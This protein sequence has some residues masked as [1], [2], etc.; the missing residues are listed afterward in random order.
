MRIQQLT[1]AE[2]VASLQ[3]SFKGLEPAEAARRLAEFGP[4]AVE[5]VRAERPFGRFVRGFTH[6]FALVLWLAAGLALVA[7]WRA[8]GQ[9]MATLAVAIVGVILINGLFSFWQEHRAERA[10]AELQRLLPHRVRVTR[11]GDLLELDTTRLVP[12]DVILLE[13]GDDVPADCRLLEA[14]GLRANNATITGESVAVSRDASPSDEPEVIH[15]TNVLLAGTQVGAGRA[16]AVVFA[17]GMHSE[18]GKIAHLTQTAGEPLSPL[19]KEI[20]RLSRIIALLAM[21]LGAVF[22]VIGLALGLPFWANLTFAIGIIIANVPEGLLPTVTLALAMGSQRMARRN[23][24][25][26]HLPSVEALGSATV[27]CTDKTG[28]LTQNC[29][30]VREVVVAGEFHVAGEVP[31][32]LDG[33]PVSPWRHFIRVAALCQDVKEVERNGHLQRA[34]DPMELAMLSMA[35]RATSEFRGVKRIGELPFDGDRKRLSTLNRTPDGLVFCTKGAPETV[36]P[37]CDRAVD[38]G[39][40]VPITA[41]L[42]EQHAR[43]QQQMAERGL[44]VLAFA[45]REVADV[46]T[47]RTTPPDEAQLKSIE[48]GGLVLCGLVGLEDPPRPEVPE[49]VRKCR[50]AGIKVIMETGDHPG[51]AVAIGRQ[52]G[53]CTGEPLVITGEQLRRMTPIQL[54]LALDAPEVIF[55]R[56]GADQKLHIVRALKRKREIVAVTGDGVNDAPALRESDIGIAMGRSGTDVAREAA[57]MVLLDDNFA[58]IVAA[59]EEGRTVYANIR[60]FITY[61]LTSNIPEIIPYLAF[62]LFRIPLPLTVVQILTVDLGTDMLPA[63]ALGAEPPQPDVMRR[64]PRPLG[65]RLFDVPLILRAYLFLGPIEAVAALASFFFVLHGAGWTYGTAL[66][67]SDPLYRQATTACL[68]AIIVMQIVNVFLCRH[69]RESSRRIRLRTAKWILLAVA[70]EVIVILLLNYTR[71]GNAVAGTAPI[72]ASVWL[73]VVPFAVAMLV[74]EEIRKG[75]VRRTAKRVSAGVP[76]LR[77]ELT[78]ASSGTPGGAKPDA[79]C[80]RHV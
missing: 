46:G 14:A 77:P 40:I 17:T 34:G 16:T 51:T 18:L 12:G 66:G 11:G 24:L 64:P 62:V 25:V 23:A 49:A 33:D 27:I 43:A 45:S 67:A 13:E 5:R 36:L 9:G 70:T 55:A 52:T 38:R 50:A 69:E 54:Q 56:A 8:P 2:A 22:F 3:S 30:T 48:D 60:K 31:A 71:A 80:V 21:A 26:R 4:N 44:R 32:Q 37:L 6:F 59:I 73:F 76:S 74:L 35:D 63:L 10:V 39:G 7:E 47:G 75:M 58:S 15:S 1:G 29:M 68:T 28:T 19:Q 72:G 41:A 42:L 79:G 61:I 57:D 78:A 20:I 53:L 65:Q